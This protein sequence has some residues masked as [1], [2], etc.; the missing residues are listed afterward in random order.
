MLSFLSLLLALPE[1]LPR[2]VTFLEF[3]ADCFFWADTV[4]EFD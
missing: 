1:A 4:V 2:A 3:V